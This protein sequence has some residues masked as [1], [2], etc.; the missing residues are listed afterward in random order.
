MSFQVQTETLIAHASLW[1]GHASDAAT[2]QER[3]EPAVGKGEDFGYLA[4][5]N[6]VADYYDTWSTAMQQA[7][8]D[9]ERCFSYL[10][11]ALRSVAHSYDDSDSSATTDIGVLDAMI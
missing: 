7:L 9:A 11:A 2:A 3:I 4:G 10:E 6:E 5:L 1:A 8:V